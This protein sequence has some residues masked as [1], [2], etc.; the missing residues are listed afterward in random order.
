MSSAIEAALNRVRACLDAAG[1][2]AR[3]ERR[4]SDPYGLDELPAIEIQRKPVTGESFSDRSDRWRPSFDISLLVIDG[5]M[6]ET[7]LDALWLAVDSA[8]HSDTSLAALMK[9]LRCTNTSEPEQ[10]PAEEGVAARM[11]CTYEFQIL[12][13]R[14]DLSHVIT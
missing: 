4:R 9:G 6:A 11:V 12:T 13:R 2:G 8:L 10:V 14:G 3:V 5:Q 1:T 7:E